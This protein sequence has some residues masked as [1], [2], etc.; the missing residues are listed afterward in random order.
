MIDRSKE[1]PAWKRASFLALPPNSPSSMGARGFPRHGGRTGHHLSQGQACSRKNGIGGWPVPHSGVT[2]SATRIERRGFRGSDTQASVPESLC[3][4]QIDGGHLGSCSAGDLRL[5]GSIVRPMGPVREVRLNNH[6]DRADRG[7]AA[8]SQIWHFRARFV[9]T[10]CRRRPRHCR[11]YEGCCLSQAWFGA[12]GVRNDYLGMGH[13]S[14]L[15]VFRFRRHLGSFRGSRC[16]ADDVRRMSVWIGLPPG[17]PS[18]RYQTG[19]IETISVPTDP[20]STTSATPPA[21]KVSSSA[22][23]SFSPSTKAVT[24]EPSTSS[25]TA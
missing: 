10:E 14:G 18:R 5:V 6:R 13:L 15:V 11:S 1:L 17:P 25:L 22:S 23:S 20:T 19:R 16:A 3:V 24:R 9:A 21:A 8:L 2:S 4:A 7:I 12:V